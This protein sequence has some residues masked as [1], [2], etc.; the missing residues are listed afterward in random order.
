MRRKT[1]RVL[2]APLA[3]GLGHATR[4]IPVVEKLL[5]RNCEVFAVLTPPQQAVYEQHFGK[6][7]GYVSFNEKPV[8]YRYSFAVSMVLQLRRFVRQMKQEE[9]LAEQLVD[10]L[11]PDLIISDNRFGFRHGD[12]RSV[13]ISHQL[14]LRA[15]IWSALANK[16]NHT[17]LNRFDD[18]WVPDSQNSPGLSGKLSHGNK[19][20]V[21]ANYIG[22]VSR[23]KPM[24]GKLQ[25]DLL[26]LLS[27][28]EPQRSLL[29][30][31][32][33]TALLPEKLKLAVVRGLPGEEETPG[34]FENVSWHNHLNSDA[35]SQV[36]AQSR[37][38]ICR[39]GYS[40]LMD[41]AAVNRR[42][43]L[44]PTPGQT[45]QEYLAAHFQKEFGF[46]VLKQKHIPTIPDVVKKEIEDEK[47]FEFSG[48]HTINEVLDSVIKN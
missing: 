13:I 19:P 40:T 3:W 16:I 18:L 45:E 17:L 25:Y 36:I 39:S 27:G 23:L 1:K 2:I 32:L 8:H 21:A 37:T 41:L 33:L 29:E 22:P 31:K 6:R 46:N 42:A 38:I 20:D 9:Q 7:I 30:E 44:I 34:D 24:K 4:C 5:Q 12:V 26:I 35:L 10:K 15:G 28:P 47:A 11:Q 43:I 14:Q 48:N